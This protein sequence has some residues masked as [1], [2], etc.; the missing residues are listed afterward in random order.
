MKAENVKITDGHYPENLKIL[1]HLLLFTTLFMIETDRDRASWPKSVIICL[2]GLK[3]YLRSETS[4]AYH[5]Y[6]LKVNPIF[7][8]L[9]FRLHPGT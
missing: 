5:I 6:V 3:K 7:K 2:R 9:F 4:A 8:N 1:S